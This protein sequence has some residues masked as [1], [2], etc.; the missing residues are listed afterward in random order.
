[1]AAAAFGGPVAEAAMSA[2]GRTCP[3]DAA[4]PLAVAMN[5]VVL[6]ACFGPLT[7]WLACRHIGTRPWA[8]ID[9]VT[10]PWIAAIACAIIAG[11]ATRAS[12]SQGFGRL[13]TAAAVFGTAAF[14]TL[15]GI[16]GA[17]ASRKS[18]RHD[19]RAL[20][21]RLASKATRAGLRAPTAP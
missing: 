17:L 13:G 18:T 20:I 11:W 7:L 15:V 3:P 8:I 6:M 10:R 21:E 12:E 1:M 2:V 5:G 4:A 9:T 14:M 16:A 19:A